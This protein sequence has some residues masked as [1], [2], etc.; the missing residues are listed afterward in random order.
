MD[1]S[2]LLKP[3]L[4]SGQLKCIGATTYTEFRGVFDKDSA[5]SRRFQKID[6]PEP[7]VAE[8]IDILKGLKSRFE[9]HHG[10]KYSN[11]ALTSAVELSAR[12][13]TDRHLPDM[14]SMRPGR[15]SASCRNRSRKKPSARAISRKSSP[16]LRAFRR[17]TCQWMIV[18][19]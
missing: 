4:S 19:R 8:T 17:N 3:A 10:I 11:T 15:R 1:A 7:S 18:V 13:I 2:N 16:R 5:L 9:A 14:S 12:Y 6:V